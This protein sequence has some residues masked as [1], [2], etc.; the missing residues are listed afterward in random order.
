MQTSR[1]LILFA[2][3]DEKART[4]ILLGN[5]FSI[6]VHP[7]FSYASLRQV[8]VDNGYLTDKDIE[9]FNKFNTSDFERLMRLLLDAMEV[10]RILGIEDSLLEKRYRTM[11]DA[12]VKSVETIH[13]SY[14]DVRQYW[15]E[16]VAAELKTYCKVF[17]T[18]YD[19]LLYWALGS[20]EFRGFTDFFWS[21]KLR[22]DSLNVEKWDEGVVEVYYLHGALFIFSDATTIYKLKRTMVNR[23]QDHIR[24]FIRWRRTL[25]LFV[26]EGDWRQKI[27]A[28]TRSPYLTFAFNSFNRIQ[29]GLV[30]YGHSLDA[31]SDAHILGAINQNSNLEVV[32][33]SIFTKDKSHSDV[34]EAMEEYQQKLRP[35]LQQGGTL[36]FFGYESSPF[37]YSRPGTATI[38][39]VFDDWPDEEDL[40][41]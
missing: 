40:P 3:V 25:P 39:E 8:A 6:G 38:G 18:N 1:D 22:F 14:D 4:N 7:L 36:Q 30:I 23:L 9:L 16:A 2:D 33:I 10:N 19:L 28:I 24:S 11:R 37:L 12:L 32:A 26:S 15:L 34:D 35:Y 31:K 20:T 5:G 41:F 13:P 17:T 27:N 29:R 21:G